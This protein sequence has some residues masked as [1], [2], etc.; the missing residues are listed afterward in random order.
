MQFGSQRWIA[1]G[2]SADPDPVRA[3]RDAVSQA[4][5]GEDARL[6]MLFASDDYDLPAL[7]A[8]AHGAGRGARLV[9]CSTAGEIATGGPGEGSVVCAAFGGPGFSI[10]AGVG[11]DVSVD[12]RRA[13]AAA[14]ACAAE[15]EERPHKALV[16]LPDGLSGNHQAV[17]RGAH[18]VVGSAIP[19]VG[20]CAGDNF[21]LVQTHQFLDGEVLQDAVVAA[22]IGSDAPL[23]IGVRH[24]WKR[25]GEPMVVTRSAGPQI[26]TLDDRPALDVYLERLEAPAAV[27]HDA[28]AFRA[29]AIAH[30]LG[31]S[32][33]AGEEKIRAVGGADFDSRSL[34]C[35]AEMPTAAL[36]WIMEGDADSVMA[37]TDA[38]C[39]AALEALGGHKPLGLLAFDCIARRALLGDGIDEEVQRLAAASDA[40]VAGFYTYGEIART[41]GLAGIHNQTLVVLAVA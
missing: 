2:A 32:R 10:A 27:G 8:A 28:E 39:E 17:V 36:A 20:G 16:L 37:A 6:L 13:G 29:F 34:I 14:A 30:P 4:L 7:V 35:F 41:R 38:A 23:G 33:R 15:L 31:L 40:P 1:V 19:L 11:R 5:A 21:K 22:A 3:G 26:F 18:S 24:G 9:G 12:P 25:S